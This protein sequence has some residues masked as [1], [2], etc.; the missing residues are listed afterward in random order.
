[1]AKKGTAHFIGERV[2]SILLVPLTIWFVWSIVSHGGDSRAE[3]MTWLSDHPWSAALPLALVI[4]VSFYHMQLGMQVIIED[5]IT[6]PDFRGML[7]FANTLV[8]LLLGAGA[9]WSI[10]AITLIA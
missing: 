7:N 4:L 5:Y 1:M 6:K 8:C 3:L 2:T 10:I 9:L